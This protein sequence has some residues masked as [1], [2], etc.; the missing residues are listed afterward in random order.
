MTATASEILGVAPDAPDEEVE[1]AY[2]RRLRGAH[3]DKGGSPEQF[4]A[5]QMA[6]KELMHR[7]CPICGGKGQVTKV[8][9]FVAE[10]T[11][12]PRCWNE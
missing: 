8:H 12:C 2:K 11:N 10:T 1:L 9:G 5:V 3:P 6:Y 7:P 4:H